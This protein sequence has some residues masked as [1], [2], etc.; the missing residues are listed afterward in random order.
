MFNVD[1]PGIFA[2]ALVL[3]P[4]IG[5]I[6]ALA[7]SADSWRAAKRSRLAWVLIMLLLNVPGVLLYLLIARPSVSRHS[8]E[9]R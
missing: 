7:H 9:A 4:V 3:L 2:T 8:R 1:A 5:I 6:D